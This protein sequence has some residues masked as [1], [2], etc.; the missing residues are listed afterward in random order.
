MARLQTPRA[1]FQCVIPSACPRCS[2]ELAHRRPG[3]GT[4]RL[5]LQMAQA[6]AHPLC[7]MCKAEGRVGGGGRIGLGYA[8]LYPLLDRAADDDKSEWEHL[9][10][11]VQLM[12]LAVLKI[13]ANSVW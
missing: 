9:F 3:S 5:W 7:V 11:G 10:S 1:T 4:A 13:P 6:R 12:E 8:A 2:R